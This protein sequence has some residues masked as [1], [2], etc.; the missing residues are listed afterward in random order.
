MDSR[1]SVIIAIRVSSREQMEEGYGYDAQVRRLPQLVEEQG[2]ALARR[3]DGSPGIYDEGF[4]STT[5]E[6]ASQTSLDHRPVMQ[7]LLGELSYTKPTYLLCRQLDRLYRDSYEHALMMKL[8]VA[9]G[10]TAI[11]EAP[12]LTTVSVRDLSDPQIKLATDI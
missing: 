6:D 11:V 5:P 4:A 2:W 1:P 9:Q 7:A 12:S 8:L 10:V 3:P